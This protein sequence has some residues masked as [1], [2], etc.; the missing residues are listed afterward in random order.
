MTKTL[1]LEALSHPGFDHEIDR[2]L[3]EN[4]RAHSFNH[5]LLAALFEDYRIDAFKV[6][7]V[8]QQQSRRTGANDSY[9][10]MPHLLS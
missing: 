2:T 3:L 4:P 6:Q 7:K 8:P 1:A 10:R 5:V 9:L